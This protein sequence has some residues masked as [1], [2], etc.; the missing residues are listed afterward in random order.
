MKFLFVYKSPADLSST[1]LLQFTN[2]CL[3]KWLK[4][5]DTVVFGKERKA[6]PVRSQQT[7]NQNSFKPNQPNQNRFK[8][9]V[10]ITEEL[11][12]AE[13]DQYKRPRYKVNPLKDHV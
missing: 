1:T 7:L 9:K 13:L 6:R 3:L 2:R 4:S 11:L 5:W 12:E 8:S 10:E